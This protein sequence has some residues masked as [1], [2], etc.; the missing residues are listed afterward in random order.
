MSLA[1]VGKAVERALVGTEKLAPEVEQSIRGLVSET[2]R[3]NP[4]ALGKRK[5][6]GEILIGK[7]GTM[8]AL[9]GRYRQGGVLGPG[10]LVMGELALDPRFKEL[11]RNYRN[12]GSANTIIN[13]YTGETISRAKAKRML[14][15]KGLGQ[16]INPLFLLGFPLSDMMTSLETAEYDPHG[17]MSGLLGGLGGGIGFAVGGPLGLVGGIGSSVLGES[18]GSTLGSSFDPDE[19][20]ID[21]NSQQS[22]RLP[23]ASNLILDAAANR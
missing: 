12:S 16:S 5:L 18:L 7:K 19:P 17:G 10:G 1:R 11:V 22:A 4:K 9:K 23:R 6:L 8:D 2:G 15:T 13:P 21:F 20:T 3:I 14:A